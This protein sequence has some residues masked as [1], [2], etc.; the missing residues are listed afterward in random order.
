VADVE[1]AQETAWLEAF[2]TQLRAEGFLCWPYMSASALP[3]DPPGYSVWLAEWNGVADVPPVHDVIAHQYAHDLPYQGTT[4]DLS[5]VV[6]VA[7]GSFGVGPR[8]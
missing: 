6:S 1:A 2:G 8:R 7:L 3:S 5:M 4:V